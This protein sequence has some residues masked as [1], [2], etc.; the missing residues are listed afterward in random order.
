[1]VR[2][3][4]EIVRFGGLVATLVSREM[5]ARYRG[6]LLGFFWSLVNPLLLTVVYTFVFGFVFQPP[7]AQLATPYALFLITGLFPWIWTSTSLIE[8]TMSLLSNAGLIR[9]AVFP[10]AILPVVS[11][12]SNLM[13]F[14][15]ALPVMAGALI[16]GRVLGFEV[17]GWTVL[18]LPLVVTI[19]LPL[20]AGMALG[21][22]AL[23]AHFK[24]VK[25]I[26]INVLTLGFFVT[27]ILYPMEAVGYMWLARLIGW[28]NPFTPFT[29]AYQSILFYGQLPDPLIWVKMVAWALGSW[30]VGT[31][32]FD[33]LS[34]SLVEAV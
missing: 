24:D 15:L 20:V 23:N 18:L 7:R 27:P 22:A 12:F 29:L 4:A 9:K 3:A 13:H 11:V 1:M 10:A 26:L 30:I 16:V 25:D 5:K 14:I 21:L 17:G 33:R 34:D 8:G 2:T 28:F 19:Q 6:S 31:W 32:I